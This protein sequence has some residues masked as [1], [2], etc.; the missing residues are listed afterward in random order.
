MNDVFGALAFAL[1]LGGLLL[2]Y[3]LWTVLVRRR[4][5]RSMIPF[6]V[7]Y[8]ALLSVALGMVSGL[9]GWDLVGILALCTLGTYLGMRFWALYLEKLPPKGS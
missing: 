3:M 4:S 7:G 9:R 5:Y 8:I 1:V 6:T 2:I